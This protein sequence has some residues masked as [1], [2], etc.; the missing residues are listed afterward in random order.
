MEP[1]GTKYLCGIGPGP[2]DL[3]SV[4]IQTATLESTV[5]EAISFFRATLW[6][7]NTRKLIEELLRVFS[8]FHG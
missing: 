5:T 8:V 1:G 4:Q 3:K 6:P 2:D 7:R